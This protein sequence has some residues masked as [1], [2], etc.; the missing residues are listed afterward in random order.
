MDARPL[1]PNQAMNATEGRSSPARTEQSATGSSADDGEACNRIDDE[2]RVEDVEGDVHEGGSE[3]EPHDEGQQLTAELGELSDFFGSLLAVVEPGAE[4]DTGHEHGDEAVGVDR[5]R[6]C[7]RRNRDGQ[8][9][10]S[11]ATGR[12]PL[13]A[14]GDHEQRGA[15]E[16]D[17][18]PDDDP[19]AE[20]AERLACVV[21]GAVLIHADLTRRDRQHEG[22]D[23]RGDTVVEPALDV[24]SS[25]EPQ[26]DPLV[27]DHLCAEGG[28]CRRQ[29]RT[30]E[31]RE[32]P[33]NVEKRS[34]K[35]AAKSDGQRK[36]D[37]E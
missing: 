14:A 30:D 25:P 28:V 2:Q 21:R 12:D 26:R 34:G 5:E 13:M 29:R 11:M 10:Q 3:Q 31:A 37:R 32:C 23:R 22:D 7:E 36:T 15:G 4:R 24:Q 20:L 33:R 19:P 1:G 9:R 6:S 8:C 18:E 16:S 35:Q 17:D 27:V